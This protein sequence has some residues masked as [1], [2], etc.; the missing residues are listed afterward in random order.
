LVYRQRFTRL[1]RTIKRCVFFTQLL[2]LFSPTLKL[3][4]IN[5]ENH[6]ALGINKLYINQLFL[7]AGA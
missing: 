5:I 7:E 6:F 2:L 1:W 4:R 3:R